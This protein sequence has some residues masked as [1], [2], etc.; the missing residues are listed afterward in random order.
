MNASR[1]ELHFNRLFNLRELGLGN[2]E[3]HVG[4]VIREFLKIG[5]AVAGRWIEMPYGVLLLQMVPGSPS[6]GAIYLYDRK[7]QVFY[8]LGFDGP[9]DN[10]TVQE[11]EQ[12]VSEYH[13]LQYAERPSRLQLPNKPAAA[14]RQ[15]KSLPAPNF[16][17]KEFAHLFSGHGLF[18]Y[19]ESG[20]GQF[21]LHPPGSA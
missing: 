7:Q 1:G 13:L 18:R 17:L 20:F 14:N 4:R 15:S 19:A 2:C 5:D 3:P 10:L 9:E 6:S 16:T 11:F 12:L 8:M 21:N